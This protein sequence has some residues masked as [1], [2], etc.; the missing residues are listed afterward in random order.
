MVK[1][2]A[3]LLAL[4][5]AAGSLGT[6]AGQSTAKPRQK[7]AS[8]TTSSLLNPASLRAKAPDVYKVKFS[9]TKGD[10]VVQVTRAWSPLGADRF[11]NLTK[12]GFYNGASFYRVLPGFVVQFGFS[13]KPEIS[14]VWDTAILKD[15]PVSQSNKRGTLSFATAGP[16]TRTT[17][18]FINLAD[19]TPLNARGFSPFG[20][21]I[22]GMDIVEQLYSGYGEGT[23]QGRGPSQER[24]AAE[25]K[26]YL[27][28]DFPNL[29]SIK[30]AAVLPQAPRPHSSRQPGGAKPGDGS[31]KETR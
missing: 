8:G 22:E 25:G 9:T 4:W 31:R 18:V 30:S 29:D 28:R 26:A 12:N 15:D 14:K 27:D 23:P 11:Y 10:F 20:E 19:N 2:F 13:P 1:L 6:Q 3:P 16:N 17:Q 21:V 7:A 5:V 24:I